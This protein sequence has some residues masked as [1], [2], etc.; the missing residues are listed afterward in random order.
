M[1]GDFVDIR[2]VE[3]ND[4]VVAK[5][6]PDCFSELSRCSFARENE[7]EARKLLLLLISIRLLQKERAG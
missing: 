7:G 1:K 3:N 5:G 6:T 4:A 2:E